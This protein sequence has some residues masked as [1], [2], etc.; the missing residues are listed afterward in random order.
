MSMTKSTLIDF[1]TESTHLKHKDAADQADAS[2][3][4]PRSTSRCGKKRTDSLVA[5]R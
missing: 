4:V 2:P 1:I 3:A 5:R